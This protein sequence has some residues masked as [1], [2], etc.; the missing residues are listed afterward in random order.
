MKKVIS[1]LL[2]FTLLVAP[3]TAS[4]AQGGY[5]LD[6]ERT[7]PITTR[8]LPDIMDGW[9]VVSGPKKI[10][11]DVEMSDEESLIRTYVKNVIFAVGGP[12]W[13]LSPIVDYVHKKTSNGELDGVYLKSYYVRKKKAEGPGSMSYYQYAWRTHIYDSSSLRDSAL[14]TVKQMY[15]GGLRLARD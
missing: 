15:D 7:T 11:R 4:F 12:T 2:V 14:V 13:V 5:N 8:S 3:C 10:V 9:E 6:T 1:A